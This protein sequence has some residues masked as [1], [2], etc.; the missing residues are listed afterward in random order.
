MTD[1]LADLG[2]KKTSWDIGP[3]SQLIYSRA[4]N[5]GTTVYI[6]Q[7]N[8]TISTSG[9][10][11]IQI[12]SAPSGEDSGNPPP[13]DDDTSESTSDQ[14]S[15]GRHNYTP[16]IPLPA[17]HPRIHSHIDNIP[18][19]FSISRA[20]TLCN[21]KLQIHA[22]TPERIASAL[23]TLPTLIIELLPHPEL[24]PSKVLRIS[25]DRI[26]DFYGPMSKRLMIGIS[27][28]PSQIRNGIKEYPKRK[29]E[30][31]KQKAEQS[32]AGRTSNTNKIPL[33]IDPDMLT[34]E[35]QIW[36][37]VKENF[38]KKCWSEKKDDGDENDDGEK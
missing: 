17:L 24:S 11:N 37:D 38:W 23:A 25:N 16:S 8:R 5:T 14:T 35:E 15:T 1:Y 12:G 7:N 21:S 13:A 9:K 30:C 31:A 10:E 36:K 34:L 4:Y 28:I 2:V 33:N 22:H 6:K 29:E 20:F 18:A 26:I 19:S 27:G 32:K 3:V